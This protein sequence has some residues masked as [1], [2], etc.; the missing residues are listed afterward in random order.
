MTLSRSQKITEIVNL[1]AKLDTEQVKEVMNRTELNWYYGALRAAI[2]GKI[3]EVRDE[4]ES[5][6]K[7]YYAAIGPFDFIP[8]QV[9]FQ[10]LLVKM[11][12]L[13]GILT[14]LYKAAEALDN[15]EGR[16]IRK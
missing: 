2:S 4:Y 12:T 10:E 8:K 7:E 16:K 6:H 15:V 5:L 3:R 9:H 14:G 13:L 1:L 11:T